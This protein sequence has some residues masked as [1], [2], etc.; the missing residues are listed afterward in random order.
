MSA[1][2]RKPLK[3]LKEY[4]CQRKSKEIGKGEGRILVLEEEEEAAKKT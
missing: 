2:K 3:F 1:S 4:N